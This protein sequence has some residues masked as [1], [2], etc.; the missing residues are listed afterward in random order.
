MS[1][2]A[3]SHIAPTAPKPVLVTRNGVTKQL[4]QQVFG[5]K[6]PLNGHKFYAPVLRLATAEDDLK[7]AGLDWVI[8]AV[9]K[10]A[11][12]IFADIYTEIVSPEVP[13]EI[14]KKFKA[15][16]IFPMDVFI[17][18]AEE[19]TSGYQKMSDIETDLEEL[20]DQI[21]ACIE[22]P[23]FGETT[24]NTEDGPKTEAAQEL[25]DTMKKLNAQVR[26]LKATYALMKDKYAARVAARKAKEVTAK[27]A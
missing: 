2:E 19:F 17:H 1:T 21:N 15:D 9:N 25:E 27:A 14:S 11:R 13:T 24:D 20:Y 22:N 23:K 26:P 16:G 10:T 18:E 8:N 6:S 3:H 12:R 7:W 4:E 5:K